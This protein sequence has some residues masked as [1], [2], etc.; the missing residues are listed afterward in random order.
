[1]TL[2]KLFPF[3][4]TS[5]KNHR[6]SS[7]MT[8]RSVW[9]NLVTAYFHSNFLYRQENINMIYCF[10]YFVSWHVMV[11]CMRRAFIEFILYYHLLCVDK[12]NCFELFFEYGTTNGTLNKKFVCHFSLTIQQQIK[13]FF[14]IPNMSFMR[15]KNNCMSTT[16]VCW[17][18]DK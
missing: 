17:K 14:Y 9:A 12:F 10:L 5:N 16:L 15:K 7:Q 11:I 8:F 6:F 13:N 2:E 1:M 3:A 4:C 18:S